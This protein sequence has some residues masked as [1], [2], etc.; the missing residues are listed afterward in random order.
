MYIAFKVKEQRKIAH[1]ANDFLGICSEL[2]DDYKTE[3]PETYMDYEWVKLANEFTTEY[4]AYLEECKQNNEG[5]NF[6]TVS[7]SLL[8]LS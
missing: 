3:F 8:C 2:V 4:Y 7:D 5:T 1:R 6:R